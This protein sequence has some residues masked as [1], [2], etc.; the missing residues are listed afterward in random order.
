MKRYGKAAECAAIEAERSVM[1]TTGQSTH[2]CE[3]CGFDM[4]AREVRLCTARDGDV[5]E[6]KKR[7]THPKDTK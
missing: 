2:Y 4:K 7:T 5:C 3:C 1:L 6:P